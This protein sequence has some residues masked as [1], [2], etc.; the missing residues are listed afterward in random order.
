MTNFFF[1]T[2]PTRDQIHQILS[3]YE[4]TGWWTPGPDAVDEA[5]RLVDG[6][7]CF[8]VAESKGEIVG[9]GRA[10]SDRVSDAYIQDVAV[11]SDHKHQG[12][13]SELVARIIK[14]LQEDGIGWIGL[15]AERNSYAFYREIGFSEM[16]DALPML[17]KETGLDTE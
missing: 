13:G 1:L 16:P 6:S 17:L 2:T 4:S 7:H 15:I 10:I 9:M 12:I 14:R 8:L 5:L 3:L 11:G